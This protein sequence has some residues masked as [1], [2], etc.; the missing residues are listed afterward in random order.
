MNRE[1]LTAGI[2]ALK[3]AVEGHNAQVAQLR[4]ERDKLKEAFERELADRTAL[5]VE[6]Q[7][8]AR[9]AVRELAEL[10]Q[11]LAD[12]D[13]PWLGTSV[14]YEFVFRGFTSEGRVMLGRPGKQG[15]SYEAARTGRIYHSGGGQLDDA[16]VQ[17][18]KELWR[19]HAK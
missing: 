18:V 19:A 13:A 4:E 8:A 3:A 15:S 14:P 7:R 9:G 2:E 10:Q 6:A 5:I 11:E 16:S 12:L 1:E 17:K